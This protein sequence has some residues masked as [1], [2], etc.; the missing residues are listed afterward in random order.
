MR[1]YIE[2]K[3]EKRKGVCVSAAGNDSITKA[4]E[5][6]R[7]DFA[8]SYG[9]KPSDWQAQLSNEKGVVESTILAQPFSN[10]MQIKKYLKQELPKVLAQIQ[11]RKGEQKKKFIR[12]LAEYLGG[13]NATRMMQ[14]FQ[15]GEEKAITWSKLL[16]H[17][18]MAQ[19][20]VY[21]TVE[22][23]EKIL[24]DFLE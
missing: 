15:W 19:T 14:M 1:Y 13:C 9:G 21:K 6:V 24:Q 2:V 18:P 8:A 22:E 4:V 7:K 16:E 5:A 3:D 12:A 10:W 23:V 17:T 11:K 20:V